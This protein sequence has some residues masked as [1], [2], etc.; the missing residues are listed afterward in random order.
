MNEINMLQVQ[1]DEVEKI[2]Q[3]LRVEVIGLGYDSLET[4]VRGLEDGIIEMSKI[5]DEVRNIIIGE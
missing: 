5:V 4:L 1:C 2:V 3:D